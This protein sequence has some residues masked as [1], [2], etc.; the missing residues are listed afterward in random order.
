L[1]E[2]NDEI[3][4]RLGT[5][6]WRPLPAEDGWERSVELDELRDRARALLEEKF[7]GVD[8]WGVKDPR[9]TLTLPFWKELLPGARYVI[10]LRN[11]AD[12]VSSVQRRPD[13]DLSIGA[14]GDLWLEYI[15]RALRET[16]G[17]PR[18]LIFYED[19]FT[20]PREQLASL[21]C[22]L[23]LPMPDEDG[24]R[25]PL[26]AIERDL[27]HHATSPRE[28][29]ATW[30]I[31]TA[32]RALFLSLRAANDAGGEASVAVER[33]A[34]EQWW[35]R[36]KL[37][38]LERALE[39]SQQTNATLQQEQSRLAAVLKREHE[40][41]GRLG[42]ELEQAR[43]EIETARDDHDKARLALASLEGQLERKTRMLEVVWSSA[44]WRLTA[45]LRTA[46]QAMR[47]SRPPT[48]TGSSQPP[49]QTAMAVREPSLLIGLSV[50]Q[51]W[52]FA[53]ILS[54]IVAATDAFLPHVVLITLLAVGPLCG[55]LTG[56][57]A[58]TAAIGAWVL[59]L[60]VLLSV[61]DHIWG[62]STQL[63]DFATVIVVTATSTLAAAAI[64]RRRQVHA[65]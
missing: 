33:V 9:T 45:P 59:L 53:L 23:G 40:E 26:A 13:P 14:W 55:L 1:V 52:W 12:V 38:G 11:P 34:P 2:L 49:G 35:E 27:R 54:T 24:L 8:L 60:A 62:T 29:A 42:G 28:L 65:G 64:E 16:E 22:L 17:C 37:L 5:V 10:C 15:A 4:A 58:R 6:W 43:R 20:K 51:I 19:L 47:S 41:H 36:R 46:K 57:R 48:D 44:S 30:G 50:G 56:S 21:A 25:E 32:A 61:P 31:P 18:T 3:L 63:I 7:A 39:E